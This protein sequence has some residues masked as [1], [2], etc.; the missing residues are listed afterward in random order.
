MG[1]KGDL[2]NRIEKMQLTPREEKLFCC[3]VRSFILEA[4]PIGSRYLSKWGG[5]ELSA[6]TIRNVMADLEEK[7]LIAQPHTSAGRIPTDKGYR[8]YVDSLMLMDVLTKTEQEA[9]ITDLVSDSKD[10]DA[11]LENS[12]RA[13]G[14][15]SS[16][17]GVVLAP[18]FYQGVFEK[19]ELVDISANKLL[20]VLKVKSGLVKT[21]LMEISL[22]LRSD[23]L[24]ETARILNE[25]LSGLTLLEIKQ[26]IDRRMQDLPEGDMGLVKL[27]VESADSVFNFSS[28]NHFHVCG[29][30]NI[31]KQPEFYDRERIRKILQLLDQKE[32]LVQ[33]LNDQGAKEGVSIIIGEENREALMKSCSFITA[34]YNLGDVT[35]TLGVIGPTRMD[36]EKVSALVNY[37]S[38]MLPEVIRARSMV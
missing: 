21:I 38:Q 18:R 30:E 29:T 20:V 12:S 13:L 23:Q 35:G 37:I 5:I 16:L 6:A 8:F 9:I 7:G 22:D 14:N 34:S 10:I 31:I 3:M 19:M 1:E 11:I 36:Y 17:L 33:V 4:K 24:D 15:I 28:D 27:F 2:S 25:R 26:S 32:I